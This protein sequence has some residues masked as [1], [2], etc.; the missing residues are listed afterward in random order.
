MGVDEAIFPLAVVFEEVADAEERVEVRHEGA[1]FVWRGEG[2]FAERDDVVEGE[3][4]ELA[5]AAV[6]GGDEVLAAAAWGRGLG[7]V[8]EKRFFESLVGLEVAREGA[9]SG[10]GAVEFELREGDEGVFPE[11]EE[12]SV[13]ALV[14]RDE[15]RDSRAV[16]NDARTLLRVEAGGKLEGMWDRLVMSW[17]LVSGVCSGCMTAVR[18]DRDMAESGPSM[19]QR[20]GPVSAVEG[21]TQAGEATPQAGP[22][23][24]LLEDL[25][26]H[27]PSGMAFPSKIEGFSREGDTP[28]D[29]L[30]MTVTYQRVDPRVVLIANVSIYPQGGHGA[31]GHV[32]MSAAG[33]IGQTEPEFDALKRSVLALGAEVSL[34]GEGAMKLVQRGA[35]RTGRR[36]HFIVADPTGKVPVMVSHVFLFAHGPWFISYRATFPAAL[37]EACDEALLA[38]MGALA[39]PEAGRL[40]SADEVEGGV[41]LRVDHH[42][43]GRAR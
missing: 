12:A 38:L 6:L 36:A 10:A 42:A 33:N 29:G 27:P 17:L 28:Q 31:S 5:E 37:H 35:I 34:I 25:L 23:A 1:A 15:H 30:G 32:S 40:A 2:H 19:T 16:E 39:W 9:P 43:V 26:T 14:Q 41:D 13:N 22:A 24:G 7:P 11:V 21:T 8:G 3:D 4:D 18:G 20:A